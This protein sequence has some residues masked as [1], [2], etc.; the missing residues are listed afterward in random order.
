MDCGPSTHKRAVS[1]SSIVIFTGKSDW[2][3]MTDRWVF[4]LPDLSRLGSMRR[5]LYSIYP[6]A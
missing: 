4:F 1:I 6:M 3:S 2:S 5:A